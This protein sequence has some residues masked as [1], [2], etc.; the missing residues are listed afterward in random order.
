M[1]RPW[2]LPAATALLGLLLGCKQEPPEPVRPNPTNA[3][4]LTLAGKYSGRRLEGLGVSLQGKSQVYPLGPKAS[5]AR[6][7]VRFDALAAGEYYVLVTR[8]AVP[9]S[10]G[11]RF[12]EESVAVR[13]GGIAQALTLAVPTPEDASPFADV[14]R[15]RPAP[16]APLATSLVAF[17][18][19]ERDWQLFESLQQWLSKTWQPPTK[20]ALCIKEERFGAGEYRS[21]VPLPEDDTMKAYGV[22]WDVTAVTLG[23]GKRYSSQFT[24]MPPDKR[25][26]GKG[27]A[28]GVVDREEV[29]RWLVATLGTAGAPA[30]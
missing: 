2:S 17:K 19:G 10:Q 23:D 18:E 8:T 11:S 30:R 28:H 26:A 9:G 24:G 29:A 27:D 12:L 7:E 6:G 22:T 15:G 21:S 3:L 5:D 20:V 1:N 14:C 16:D 4:H 13:D 25:A